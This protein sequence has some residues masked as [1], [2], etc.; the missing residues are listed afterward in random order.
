MSDT[1]GTAWR[2]DRS[3]RGAGDRRDP[4]RALKDTGAT[5]AT[6]L[7]IGLGELDDGCWSV[8]VD[9]GVHVE[10]ADDVAEGLRTLIA[11]PIAVV[12]AAARWAES[13]MPAVGGRP[14]LASTHVVVA[15]GLESPDELRVALDAGADDV[16]RVPFEPEVL[17]A[18][19]AAG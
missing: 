11:R 19:V 18:R 17:V 7:L 12:I 16:M 14:E 10:R 8:L 1:R 3:R 15:T 2:S 6:V 13:L 5:G 4:A 9:A